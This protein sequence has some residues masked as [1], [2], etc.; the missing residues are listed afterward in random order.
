M[1]ILLCLYELAWSTLNNNYDQLVLFLLSIRKE[2]PLAYLPLLLL[3]L[4]LL[5]AILFFCLVFCFLCIS[6]VFVLAL[7]EALVLLSLHVNKNTL[8]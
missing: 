4:L 1:K 6:I 7:Q 8:N 5:Y 2:A 3:L